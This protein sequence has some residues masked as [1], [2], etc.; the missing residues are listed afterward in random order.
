MMQLIEPQTL[1]FQCPVCG[2]CDTDN[3]P[4]KKLATDHDSDLL[5]KIETVKNGEREWLRALVVVDM[6]NDFINGK[7]KVQYPHGELVA[8]N[9]CEI[10]RRIGK[11]YD[12]IIA[13]VDCHKA[14][15]FYDET[16]LECRIIP[17]HCLEFSEGMAIDDDV[18]KA[19]QQLI[20]DDVFVRFVKK[21]S[22]T[23]HTLAEHTLRS[24]LE[25]ENSVIDVVGLCT[26]VCVISTALMLR[27][28][29]PKAKIRII[30]D[31]CAGTTEKRHQCALEV[32]DSCLIGNMTTKEL[33]E[34][35]KVWG[36]IRKSE[37]YE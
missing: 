24:F 4:P 21:S 26:D 12:T 5:T 27:S 14:Q 29:F 8:N 18:Y 28:E 32:M 11:D 16:N 37:G 1:T 34:E 20:S 13:T 9:V 36:E 15:D 23:T 25:R 31:A 6:Q 3:D 17:E 7:L 22:F 10:L 19:L 35:E 33:I 2:R 30:S